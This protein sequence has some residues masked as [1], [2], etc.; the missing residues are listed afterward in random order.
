MIKLFLGNR[1]VV[2]F[3]L[4][5]VIAIYVILNFSS[6]YFTY[7]TVSNF[8][9]W[10]SQKMPFSILTSQIVASFFVLFNALG[11]NA[12]FNWNEFFGERFIRTDYS[13]GERYFDLLKFNFKVEPK[14]AKQIKENDLIMFNIILADSV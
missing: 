1:S 7:S 9:F 14:I 5:F 8:G 4:P 2:L 11:I 6:N 10:G 12:I 3:L 13:D